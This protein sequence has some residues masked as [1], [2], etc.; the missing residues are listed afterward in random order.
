MPDPRCCGEQGGGLQDTAQVIAFL[1]RVGGQRPGDPAGA[2]RLAQQAPLLQAAEH[3]ADDRAADVEVG[4]HLG[5]HHAE[6]AKGEAGGD[7]FLDLGGDP[8]PRGAGLQRFVEVVG[9][10]EAEF[11][12]IRPHRDGSATGTA[13]QKTASFEAVDEIVVR[14]LG[15]CPLHG[16]STGLQ[17]G[18]KG[19]LEQHLAARQMSLEDVRA[20]HAIHQRVTALEPV[21]SNC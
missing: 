7:G 3:V 6:L 13:N 19:R 9:N 2:L 21:L 5:L 15:E 20:Q 1:E 4:R 10:H 16:R 12:Q 14:Q 8:F 11:P 18:C 17:H